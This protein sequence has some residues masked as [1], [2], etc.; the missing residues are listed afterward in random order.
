MKK[1]IG[2]KRESVKKSIGWGKGAQMGRICENAYWIGEGFIVEGGG[3]V[4]CEAQRVE[5]GP[6]VERGSVKKPIGWRECPGT[7]GRGSVKRPIGKESHGGEIYMY[8]EF[9]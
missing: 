1:P 8:K 7:C 3:R 5:E 6:I 4:I 9:Q 2:W